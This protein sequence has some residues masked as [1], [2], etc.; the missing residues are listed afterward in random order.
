MGKTVA[1]YDTKNLSFTVNG[2]E[3]SLDLGE[4]LLEIEGADSIDF[5]TSMSGVP[6]F[7]RKKEGLHRKVKFPVIKQSSL[8]AVLSGLE[9]GGTYF[10]FSMTDMNTYDSYVSAKCIVMKPASTKLGD[11][12]DIEWEIMATYIEPTIIGNDQ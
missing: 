8:N 1:V 6:L 10:S 11:N 7:S 3:H 5:R 12:S 9:A 4:G 2:A